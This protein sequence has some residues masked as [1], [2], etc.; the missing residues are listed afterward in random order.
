MI[1]SM[2]TSCAR[3]VTDT[4]LVD[5]VTNGDGGAFGELVSRHQRAVY[6]IVSRLIDNREDV[7]DAVQEVFVRAYSALRS[8]RRDAAFSTWLHRIAVNTTIKHMRLVSRR[9]TTS[10]DDPESGIAETLAA[11]ASESP[12]NLSQQRDRQRSLREA[13]RELP[14]KHRVVVSLHY[15][16]DMPCEEIAKALG[17]SKGTVW[18]RLHYGCRKL[19]ARLAWLGAE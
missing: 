11:L 5:M 3:E 12:E 9:V 13:V 8:F 17:C 2:E 16:Q 10:V 15:F 18:S 7:D 4:D 19:Q 14:E 6:G 1:N